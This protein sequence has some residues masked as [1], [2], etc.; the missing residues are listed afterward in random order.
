MAVGHISVFGRIIL[1]FCVSAILYYTLWVIGL[2][3]LEP[4]SSV[5]RFFPDNRFAVGIPLVAFTVVLSGLAAYS[6]FLMKLK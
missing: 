4:K 5:H 2:P 1:I 3:L 6:Q